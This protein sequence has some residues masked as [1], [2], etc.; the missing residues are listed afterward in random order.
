MTQS[1]IWNYGDTFTSSRA[2]A[3]SSSLNTP[4]VYSGFEVS[5]IDTTTFALSPGVLLLPS[6]VLV[7]EDYPIELHLSTAPALPTDYTITVRHTDTDVLGGQPAVYALE[8][9]I[10]TPDAVVDGIPIVYLRH[11]GSGAAFSPEMFVPLRH[12]LGEAHDSPQLIPTVIAAPLSSR[13]VV[14]SYSGLYSSASSSD[15]YSAPRVL[16]QVSPDVLFTSSPP[17]VDTTVFALPLTAGKFPPVSVGVRATIPPNCTITVS[18][19]DTDGNP[20]SLSGSTFGA[21]SSFGVRYALVVPGS[22]V[23]TPGDPYTLLL[24]LGLATTS[25]INIQSVSVSYDPLP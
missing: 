14:A 18:L 4:G 6:G 10:I 5:I 19:L 12:V 20:V 9:G 13:W 7:Q 11:P 15:I 23:F 22:G 8:N 17:A 1:R 25:V 16:T 3:L 24:S 2:T 21:S